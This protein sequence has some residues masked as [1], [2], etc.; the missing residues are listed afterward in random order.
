MNS[1]G[2]QLLFLTHAGDPG[3]AEYKMIDL[4]RAAGPSAE[5]MLLQHGSLEA[6]LRGHQIRYSVAPMSRAARSVR[7]EGGLLSILKAVPGTLAMVGSVVR[8]GRRS[9]ALV[10]FSQKSFVLASLAKAFM[11]RPIVW[12]MND[13]LS[14][15][16]F[17][18]W[19]IRMLVAVS[20]Y[21]ADHVVLNSQA[22]LSAWTRAG[23]RVRNVSVIYPGTDESDNPDRLKHAEDVASYKRQY[24]PEGRPLIGM[25]GRISRWKGQHVFLKAIARLPQVNAIVVGGSLFDEEAYEKSVRQLAKELGIEHRVTFTGHVSDVM[26]R[27]AACDVVAHCSTAPEP[28]GLVIVQAMLAGVPVIASDAGGAREIVTEG[29]TGQLTPLQDDAALA[30]AIRRYLDDPRW[31][32]DLAREARERAKEKFSGA[33][34]ANGFF[35]VLES[36]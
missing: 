22:S 30:N 16:H 28:F 29:R 34:M 32:I 35:R 33:A 18:P 17:S 19:L 5:V 7:K 24:C 26:T 1:P 25:F 14:P 12:F 31:S 9:G 4:C 3:G 23:G 20:R 15:E 11:R 36:L 13:I 27:M 2:R 6:L 10:C 8:A 21:S